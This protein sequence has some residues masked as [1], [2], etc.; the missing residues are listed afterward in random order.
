VDRID[1]ELSD[2]WVDPGLGR[3][4]YWVNKFTWQ[5]VSLTRGLGWVGNWSETFIF[6]R[7]GWVTGLKWQICAKK[8]HASRV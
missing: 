2:G 5:W 1:P 4:R 7:L 6:S 3:V 8:K